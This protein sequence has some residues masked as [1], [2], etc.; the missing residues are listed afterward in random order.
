MS[1]TSLCNRYSANI[2][3]D[4][5]AALVHILLLW[6]PLFYV[7]CC[8]NFSAGDNLYKYIIV[9]FIIITLKLFN[10]IILYNLMYIYNYSTNV[11]KAPIDNIWRQHQILT[12]K[13]QCVHYSITDDHYPRNSM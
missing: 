13:A 8:S 11:F 9:E 10:V 12:E 1:P 2:Y 4:L 6:T 5:Y 3:R 7:W